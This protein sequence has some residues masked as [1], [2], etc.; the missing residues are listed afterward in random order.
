MADCAATCNRLEVGKDG[1][2]AYERTKEK[3]ATFLGVEFGEKLLWKRKT[4]QKMSKVS[5]EWEY[6]IFVVVRA[7]SGE[8]WVVTPEGMRKVRA[9]R[10]MAFQERRVVAQARGSG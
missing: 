6:V 2:T 5:P 4:A 9:V 8:L 3:A 7:R 1:K 10:R